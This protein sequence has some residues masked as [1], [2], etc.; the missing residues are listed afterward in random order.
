MFL[1]LESIESFSEQFGHRGF[2]LST[3]RFALHYFLF[4]VL[5]NSDCVEKLNY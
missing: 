1:L 3:V 5:G 4:M 2:S